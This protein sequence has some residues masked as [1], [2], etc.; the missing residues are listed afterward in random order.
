MAVAP[1]LL[2]RKETL[3]RWEEPEV[4]TPPPRKEPE[5]GSRLGWITLM[6]FMVAAVSVLLALA[7]YTDQKQWTWMPLTEMKAV[8][9]GTTALTFTYPMM[10]KGTKP[11]V[12]GTAYVVR[13]KGA[14]PTLLLG[15]CPQHEVIVKWDA[16]AKAFICPTDGVKFD[17]RG[18]PIGGTTWTKLAPMKWKFEGGMV[19]VRVR[20]G[21]P[22]RETAWTTEYWAP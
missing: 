19:F 14:I 6:I 21:G 4:E 15:T 3:L 2:E 11:A 7:Y 9:V 12:K 1:E 20:K 13:Q 5:R 22:E 8:P 10:G 16:Q 17:T 18:R